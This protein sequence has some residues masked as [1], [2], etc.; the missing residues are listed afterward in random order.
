MHLNASP[1]GELGFSWAGLA[2]SAGAAL[3]AN[4]P[5]F[6]KAAVEN[7]MARINAKKAERLARIQTT[8]IAIA[9]DT[10]QPLP[11]PA[12]VTGA[13]S[14]STPPGPRLPSW[15]LPVALGAGLLAVVVL[16]K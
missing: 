12:A 5:D 2:T 8:G 3:K 9:P 11:T 16:R 6:L 15:L 1:L 14:T 7:R 4:G 10:L 13:A